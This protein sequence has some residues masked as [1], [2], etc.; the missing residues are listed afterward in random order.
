MLCIFHDP[1][2]L[3]SIFNFSS[4]KKYLHLHII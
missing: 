2:K 1:Q 3:F 4:R